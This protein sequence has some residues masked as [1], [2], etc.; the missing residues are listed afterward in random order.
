VTSLPSRMEQARAARAEYRAG[1]TDLQQRLRSGVYSGPVVDLHGL[2]ELKGIAWEQDGR[3]RIGALTPIAALVSDA[4]LFAAYPALARSA[5]G[6][7][8]PQI[9]SMATL[10]GNLL[11][12][13]RCW[14]FRNPAVPCFKKGG[15]DC[16]ARNGNHLFGACFDLGGCV[17]PH[18]STLGMALLASEADFETADGSSWPIAALYGDGSDARHDH[19]LG[20]QQL[21]TAVLMPVPAVGERAA[22]CRAIS[23]AGA[24]WPLAEAVVRLTTSAGNIAFARVAVGGVAPVPL[25]L[26]RVEQAM[27]GQP[28][29]RDTLRS[30]ASH[31]ADGARPLPMTGYKPGLLRATVLEALE[32]ALQ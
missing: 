23:R 21:L 1:G 24:E 30:A 20:D 12:R 6:L 9:R 18:P 32:H 5:A 17:A 3:A 19:Q 27:V 25:R 4:R 11:Q 7:A 8:T 29:N 15:A 16:P 31:A 28:A 10:G 2:S 26:E 22:Y 14:Y 13:S